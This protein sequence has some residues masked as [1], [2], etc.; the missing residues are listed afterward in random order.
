MEY[1]LEIE[2]SDSDINEIRS[3]LIKHNTP[4][5]KGLSTKSKTTSVIW[6]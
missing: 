5:L 4:F 6:F 1:K 3:G 2:P